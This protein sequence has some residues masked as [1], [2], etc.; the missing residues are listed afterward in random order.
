MEPGIKIHLN[1]AGSANFQKELPTLL[2]F[3]ALPNGNTTAQTAGKL[4]KPG[5][6]W[7]YDIQHIA[8]QTRFLR[9]IT[10]ERNVVIAYLENTL[11]SWPA[12]RKA[13]ADKMIPEMLENIRALCATNRTEIVL[14]G[15]S[16]GGSLIFGYLNAQEKIPQEIV[17][18]AFLDSNYAYER[19]QHHDRKLAEWLSS[20]ARHYLCVLAYD[21]ASALLD[22]KSFVSANGGT[23]GRSHAMQV[24]LANAMQFTSS[25]N[26]GF[27]LYSALDG[28]VQFNLKENPE[29]KVLH[30]VQVERNGFIHSMLSGTSKE[31]AGYRYF[32]DRAY[33]QIHQAR[34]I[35]GP[36]KP[37]IPAGRGIY[38]NPLTTM[39]NMP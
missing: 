2:I 17:R 7:H 30:T 33:S 1:M 23:W 4:F 26:S 28:R 14:S 25:T 27:Q 18:I 19:S 15:H 29:R 34:S 3:Y 21:D 6:D 12:W 32:G 39:P 8:A 35:V 20:S 22:G 37:R 11:K 5:D 31:S 9:K 36:R 38:I 24:D 13:N 10:P 16:G